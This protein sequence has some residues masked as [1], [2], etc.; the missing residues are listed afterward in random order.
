MS[1]AGRLPML[2][3]PGENCAFGY[4]TGFC[5]KELVLIALNSTKVASR[6]GP[7]GWGNK[8]DADG[9]VKHYE[10]VLGAVSFILFSFLSSFCRQF[11]L[12]SM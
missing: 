6:V 2:P 11:Q 1:A 12:V 10:N 9:Y 3:S 5:C 7:N 4:T 8:A